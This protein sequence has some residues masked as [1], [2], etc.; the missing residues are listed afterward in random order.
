MSLCLGKI[1][2]HESV[3]CFLLL[4]CVSIISKG[5]HYRAIQYSKAHL[6]FL[7]FQLTT[8][9]AFHSLEMLKLSL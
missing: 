9:G 5:K 3:A 7:N 8:E 4:T 6:K 1:Q 2:E